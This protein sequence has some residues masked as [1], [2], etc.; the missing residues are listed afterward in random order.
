MI[1]IGLKSLYN[2]SF[3]QVLAL[4]IIG[5]L[6]LDHGENT[7]N[8]TIKTVA[9]TIMTAS[10]FK[11]LIS[12]N[13][14]VSLISKVVR[15][16]FVDMEFLRH[17][18]SAKLFSTTKTLVEEIS[19]RKYGKIKKQLSEHIIKMLKDNGY[20]SSIEITLED[21]VKDGRIQTKGTYI[22][23]CHA[24]KNESSRNCITFTLADNNYKLISLFNNE[25]DL[26]PQ[27][28]E[29]IEKNRSEKEIFYD[30]PFQMGENKITLIE[31]YNDSDTMHAFF[32]NKIS[33]N[34]KV[35]Y[36]HDDNI[37]NPV[38]IS[39]YGELKESNTKNGELVR[40]Y[41]DQVFIADEFVFIKF[42]LK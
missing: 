20:Y 42:N 37:I 25:D 33:S 3:V 40:D 23:T 29:E 27:I 5:I 7:N 32:F 31:E 8:Q 9:I 1:W 30:I 2:N 16:S 4:I 17:F 14:F 41:G 13:A 21:S 24:T 10:L 26:T 36:K 6:L 39:K 22:I 12:A 34:V 15:E 18:K 38:I 28:S 11:F 19:E 35:I